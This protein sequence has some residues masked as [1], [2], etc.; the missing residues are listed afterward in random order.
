MFDVYVN[1]C[2]NISKKIVFFANNMTKSIPKFFFDN[3]VVYF[4][5]RDQHVSFC[6]ECN[7]GPIKMFDM[8]K[9]DSM[10]ILDFTWNNAD[11]IMTVIYTNDNKYAIGVY[12]CVNGSVELKKMIYSIPFS[13]NIIKTDGDQ[14]SMFY[15]D[16][17]TEDVV[18]DVYA[19]STGLREMHS[20]VK[21]DDGC[22][23]FNVKFG[24]DGSSLKVVTSCKKSNGEFVI[25]QLFLSCGT[26]ITSTNKYPCA[27][28]LPGGDLVY[29]N[30]AYI[31]S[32][33]EKMIARRYFIVNE[34]VR[35]WRSN[36][37]DIVGSVRGHTNI[38][39]GCLIVSDSSPE[40][41]LLYTLTRNWKLSLV[42]EE[43]HLKCISHNDIAT[44]TQNDLQDTTE[45]LSKC[46]LNDDTRPKIVVNMK[47][48]IDVYSEKGELISKR[49]KYLNNDECVFLT[50]FIDTCQKDYIPV[51][52]YDI[53]NGLKRVSIVFDEVS[54]MVIDNA[55]IYD[56]IE[57]EKPNKCFITKHKTR[58]KLF[59]MSMM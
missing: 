32:N 6:T 46:V 8:F 56:F 2:K 31:T 40:G 18:V 34:P 20:V 29:I 50:T 28:V 16:N 15:F 35:L 5:R 3:T 48:E 55:M 36:T 10:R 49:T 23:F 52:Q 54:S 37:W 22:T 44:T 38:D 7:C 39:D 33:I 51:K 9:R 13:P 42:D 17:V 26:L 19:L 53:L 4:N 47:N 25:K 24:G 1:I 58:E 45:C 30:D 21:T 14:L 41:V 57:S 12:V 59:I 27:G 11:K 43:R